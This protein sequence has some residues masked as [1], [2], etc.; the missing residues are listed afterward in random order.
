MKTTFKRIPLIILLITLL[1]TVFVA[2]KLTFD[3]SLKDWV[4]SDEPIVKDYQ[5]FLREFAGD[6]LLIVS[7]TVSRE[8]GTPLVT[9]VI[10]SLIIACTA[11][12]T[13]TP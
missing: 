8:G 1:G 6:A 10:D 12:T 9:L 3:D 11:F 7:F 2:P 4:P 5:A 13:C